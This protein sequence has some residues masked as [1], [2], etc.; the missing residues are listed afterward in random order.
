MQKLVS[1]NLLKFPYKLGD[2]KIDRSTGKVILNLPAGG[3]NNHWTRNLL[4]S[5]DEKHLFV[6]VGSAS[7]IAEHG[8]AEEK[9]RANILRVDLDGKNEVIYG[10]GLRNPVGMDLSQ[11]GKLWTVVNER[12][13]L[14]D[15][16]VPDYLTEV[17]EG[18]FYGWPYAYYGANKDPR[19][20]DQKPELVKK[21][22]IPDVALGSHTASLGLAFYD[23]EKFPK[24]YHGGAFIG[25]HGSW[26]RSEIVG[27]QVAFVPFKN[28]KP[29]GKPEVFLEGFIKD[30]NQALVYGRP[31]SVEVLNNGDIL[32]SDDASDSIWHVTYKSK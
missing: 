17:S 12:D 15:D 29:S 8:M 2:K 16:L 25:Q 18:D 5:K 14:G 9:R 20:K 3:Y 4:L 31:V 22:L 21:T 26:N 7:N 13:M 19:V 11:T 30:K 32:V 28:G 6:S 24:K 27:Y 1:P 23:K 10:A